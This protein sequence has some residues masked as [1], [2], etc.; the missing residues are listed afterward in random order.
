MKPLCVAQTL[1]VGGGPTE[2]ASV[3]VS[4]F[5]LADAGEREREEHHQ[6]VLDVPEVAKGDGL[7]VLV[8]EREVR[9]LVAVRKH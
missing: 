8:L 1:W 9:C 5:A 6:H 3:A 7:T 4:S 2:I